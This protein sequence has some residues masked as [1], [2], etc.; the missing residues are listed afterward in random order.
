MIK[1]VP[2]ASP[3]ALNLLE[4]MLQYNPKKRPKPS[5]ILQHEFLHPQTHTS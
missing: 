1:F 5:Q 4:W 3:E 2:R